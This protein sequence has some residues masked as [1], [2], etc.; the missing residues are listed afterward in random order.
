MAISNSGNS[1]DVPF[2]R[3]AST[4]SNTPNNTPAQEDALTNSSDGVTNRSTNNA[5]PA[6][7]VRIS[8]AAQ[9]LSRA[10]NSDPRA[11][12]DGARVSEIAAAIEAGEYPIDSTKLADSILRL[13]Q[14][15]GL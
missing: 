9:E 6:S 2:V 10:P 12:F 14:E 5:A 1:T 11:T 4:T 3:P 7:D 13:E 8:A 15:L